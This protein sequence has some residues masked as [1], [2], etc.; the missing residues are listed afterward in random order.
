MISFTARWMDKQMLNMCTACSERI[1]ISCPCQVQ[2]PLQVGKGGALPT[3]V[4][5]LL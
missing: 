1:I 2:A 5:A 3:P 4:V